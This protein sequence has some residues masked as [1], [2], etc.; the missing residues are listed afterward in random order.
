MIAKQ[1]SRL[2]LPVGAFLLTLGCAACNGNSNNGPAP[3]AVG[4]PAPVAAVVP[5]EDRGKEQPAAEAAAPG[6][7]ESAFSHVEGA[8]A[9]RAASKRGHESAGESA[10]GTEPRSGG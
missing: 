6:S 10:P 2:R 3:P 4:E 5:A 7:D 1:L 9:E 8:E